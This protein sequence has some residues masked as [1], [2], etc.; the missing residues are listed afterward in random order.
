MNILICGGR[1][2]DDLGLMLR[3]M[4]WF[5]ETYGSPT[6]V[7]HGDARGADFLGRSWCR[8]MGLKEHRYPADWNKN[9]YRAGPIRNQQMLDEEQID[10]CIAF[11]GSNGTEDMV[12]RCKEAGISVYNVRLGRIE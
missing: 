6:D 10:F 11:P 12:R 1:D 9:G 5:C 8:M 3:A 2:F 4:N 7:T